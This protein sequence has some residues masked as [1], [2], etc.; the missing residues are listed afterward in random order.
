M[1][2]S[3]ATARVLVVANRTAATPALME[4]VR[5]RAQ[6]GPASFTLLVPSSA[7]GLH[8]LVDPED[9]GQ[10]EAE[11]TIE[12][13]LPLLEEAAGKP[14]EPMIGVHEP[15]AAIQDAINLHGP[16]DELIISTLPTR[17]SRWLKLDLPHKAAGLG[18]PV[19]TVTAKGT[20][21]IEA[22]A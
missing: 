20:E 15:L 16:F 2:S 9:Q 12:L 7:H 8:Q 11:G 5:E 6:R 4:A 22:H 21:R 13:A 14:V 3:E 18:I 10:S 17:V 1:E 19:T